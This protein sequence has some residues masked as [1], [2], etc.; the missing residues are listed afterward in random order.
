M[1]CIS[2]IR[3]TDGFPV[4]TMMKSDLNQSSEVPSTLYIPQV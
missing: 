4:Q 3:E 2:G 1:K